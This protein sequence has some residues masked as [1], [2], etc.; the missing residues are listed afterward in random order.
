[1]ESWRKYMRNWIIAIIVV[2]VLGVGGYFGWQ[3][4]RQQQAAAD[5]SSYQTTTIGRGNLTATVGAT[6]T[7]RSNQSTLLTWQTSGTVAGEIVEVGNVVQTGQ[8]LASLEEDSLVQSVILARSDL[9]AA[10][11]ALEDLQDSE[12]ERFQAWQAVL[13]ARQAIIEAERALDPYEVQDFRDDMDDARTEV[14][15]AQEALAEAEDDLEPYLEFDEENAN[16]KRFQDD[17]DEAQQ[18]Y[19]EAVR[20]LE[21]LELEQQAAE[22]NLAL[23]QAHL[24]DAERAYERVKDG[25]NPDDVAAL[26]ARIAAAEATLALA[27]LKAS[28]PS[29]VTDVLVKPGDQATPGKLAFRLDDLSMLLVDVRV[30]EVDINRVAI[31]QPVLMTFDAVLGREYNGQVTKI[32]SLGSATQGVVEFIVTVEVVDADE[33]VRPGMTAAVSIVVEELNNVLLVPNRA[34]RVLDGNRVVYL[35]QNSELT[36]VRVTLGAS[37]D[38]ESEVVDGDLK[39]GDVVVLNPPQ[40]FDTN[41]PPPFVQR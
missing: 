38:L 6:G 1:M 7:V 24:N 17:L 5:L 39:S 13:G 37:S 22:T 33:S 27:E 11:K 28:F 26:E 30:S 3:Y 34:V 15:D 16:R 21:L 32:A 12:L 35:L 9:L 2:V 8:V 25:P 29:T 41:G 23:A 14:V 19:D 18:D 10:Q 20:E 31:G 4:I 36:P 40:V